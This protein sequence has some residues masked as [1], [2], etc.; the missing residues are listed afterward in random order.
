MHM[1]T[2][3][4]I[5]LSAGMALVASVF[6]VAAFLGIM[7]YRASNPNEKEAI[8]RKAADLLQARSDRKEDENEFLAELRWK[9]PANRFFLSMPKVFGIVFVFVFAAC[10]YLF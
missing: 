5:L 6:A 4:T 8:R 7:I 10:F 3:G 2:I 1:A 9:S